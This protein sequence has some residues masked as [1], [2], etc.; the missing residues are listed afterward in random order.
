MNTMG[1]VGVNTELQSRSA[2]DRVWRD[3]FEQHLD[4]IPQLLEV[5]R[6][7]R[8]PIAA[9]RTDNERV[10]GGGG[11]APLPF[12]DDPVD[13][14]DDLWSAL[15]EYLGEVAERLQDPAPAAVGA[16]W[17]IDGAARGV[18]SWMNGDLAYKAGYALIAWLV[19]RGLEVRDLHM[20]DSEDHLFGLVRKLALRYTV[21]PIER[22]ASRRWCSVCGEKAVAVAWV[23]SDSGEAVCRVCGETYPS[24]GDAF[25]DAQ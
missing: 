8:V 7:A 14:C 16:T 2:R 18:P 3:R 6:E 25:E 9:A 17:A 4:Q 13:D 24:P 12:R 11:S 1:N 23:T 10:S 15:V 5:M 19:D 21:T 22:P 20:K